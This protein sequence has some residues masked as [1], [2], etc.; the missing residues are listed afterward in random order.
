VSGPVSPCAIAAAVAVAVG[1]P[2]AGAGAAPPHA[3]WGSLVATS[4]ALAPIR[5][6]KYLTPNGELDTLPRLGNV[7]I[8]DE[9]GNDVVVMGRMSDSSIY[10]RLFVT[11]SDNVPITVKY[12]VSL[13]GTEYENILEK[14]YRERKNREDDFIIS[15][16]VDAMKVYSDV[17]DW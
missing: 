11:F 17:C 12:D 6:A 2:A 1:A 3:S 5:T 16:A 10:T 15:L 8:K 13:D 4:A 14:D 9:T 7:C